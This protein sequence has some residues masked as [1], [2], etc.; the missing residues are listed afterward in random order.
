[1]AQVSL[2]YDPDLKSGQVIRTEIDIDTNQTL[3]IAGMP[4]ET[5]N[6]MFLVTR[7]TVGEATPQ[8]GHVLQGEFEILQ[9]DMSLPGGIT[10]NFNS[11]NPNRP[12][13]GELEELIGEFFQKMVVAKWKLTTG[14]DHK[15]VSAEYLGEPFA[16]VSEYFKSDADPK[17][18]MTRTNTDLARYPSDP[19]NVGGTWTRSEDFEAGGGQ[20]IELERKFNLLGSEVRDGRT[21]DKVGMTALSVKLVV[22]DN[23]AQPVKVTQSDLKIADS[24]G[25]LWYDRAA[26]QF[27]EGRDKVHITGTLTVEVQGMKLPGELD[28]TIETKSKSKVIEP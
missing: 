15:V 20:T 14:A 26:K 3:T 8:G 27:T 25:T 10:F 24:E 16:N 1:Q 21:F 17:L 28:L 18:L 19:V 9:S 2:K 11:N 13:S 6:S 4:L 7:E 5:G 12:L 23:P 22:A